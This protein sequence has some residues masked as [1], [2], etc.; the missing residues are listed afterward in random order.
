[1]IPLW[2]FPVAATCGN[3]YILK[4]S[5]KDPGAALLLAEMAI[6]V[7]HPP[8]HPPTPPSPPPL[9]NHPP[10]YQ[11]GLPPGVLNLVH[12]T[13][14]TVDFLCDH[15]AIKAISFV[16]GNAAGAHIFARGTAK[17]KRVQSNMGAKNHAT[18]LPDADKESVLNALTGAAFGAAGQRCMAL[19]VAVLV[20]N[21]KEWLPELIQKAGTLKVINKSTAGRG[22]ST[23]PPTPL[24]YSFTYLPTLQVGA[25]AEEG[26]DVGPLISPVRPSPPIHPRTHP[27]THL[28]HRSLS[29]ALKDC[30][31]KGWPKGLNSSW[32]DAASKCLVGGWVGGWLND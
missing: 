7:S 30:W 15:P 9:L 22:R 19:S 3:T 32:M 29:N 4:P 6:E 2:M 23:H 1:M 17:G 24:I 14:H 18:I 25:G 28:F 26:T 13:H 5:E 16:G 21:A 31:R 10:T 27:P 12:G 8:T 11:A 20:G